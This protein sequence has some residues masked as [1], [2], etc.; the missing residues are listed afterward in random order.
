ME[1]ILGQHS[2]TCLSRAI[3]RWGER[4]DEAKHDAFPEALVHEER[5]VQ[6]SKYRR[7]QRANNEAFQVRLANQLAMMIQSRGSQDKIKTVSPTIGRVCSF[8]RAV[9]YNSSRKFILPT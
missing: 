9:T 6:T 3:D 2:N 1:Q 8:G 5:P 4:E 7:C